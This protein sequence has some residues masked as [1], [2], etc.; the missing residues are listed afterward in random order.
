MLGLR[1]TVGYVIVISDGLFDGPLNGEV[2]VVDS[3]WCGWTALRRFL[4]GCLRHIQG[5]LIRNFRLTWGRD[6]GQVILQFSLRRKSAP[7]ILE[8]GTGYAFFYRIRFPVGDRIAM[9]VWRFV[10]M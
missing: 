8:A 9:G 4:N 1:R 10:G 3:G 5:A 6:A 2:A 7:V